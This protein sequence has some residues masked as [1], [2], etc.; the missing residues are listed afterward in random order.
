MPEKPVD[1]CA[2]AEFPRDAP[3]EEQLRFLIGYAIMAPSSHN[4][5]PWIWEVAGN[6]V[7]LYADRSRLMPALDPE[8][9]ELIISCGAA[10]E[11]LRLA[12]HA[13]GCQ[14]SIALF[15]DP[16]TPDLLARVD[17]LENSNSTQ[18]QAENKLPDEQALFDA[19][20][21]RH[22]NRKIFDA[23][24]LPEV[25]LL[26][27]QAEAHAMGAWLHFLQGAGE[28]ESV[29][30]L[31]AMGEEIQAGK[32]GI[33]H[34]LARWMSPNDDT[35]RDGIPGYA[36]GISDNASHV[37]S[38][39]THIFGPNASLAE[40]NSLLAENAPVLVVLGAAEDGPIQWL[41]AGR[42]LA[43]VLLRASAAGV[44]A[45]FFSQPIQVHV[46]WS[47]LRRTLGCSDFP[48]LIF[49]LGYPQE[50]TP[51]TPRRAVEEVTTPDIAARLDADM[52]Q[53]GF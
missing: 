53:R 26:S 43:R 49:R 32:S 19:I 10:L 40:K 27:L 45:S 18:S 22:T 44:S 3:P 31:I 30:S 7:G 41:A 17:L 38:F 33:R 13:F 2:R 47:E 5:Q 23:K 28:R 12:M 29:S 14:E 15:P 42:A 48:Q 52:N 1:E 51:A 35:R 20:A 36:Q 25:L 8:G 16:K 34:D 37:A 46:L 9:R 24:P 21:L 11:H 4:T 6:Q 50:A 39:W